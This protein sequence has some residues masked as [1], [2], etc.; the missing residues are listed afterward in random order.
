MKKR[1]EP[2]MYDEFKQKLES[3]Q[4][5]KKIW[6]F[7]QRVIREESFVEELE[8]L[9]AEWNI[10]AKGFVNRDELDKWSLETK[11]TSD[12]AFICSE[13]SL[14]DLFESHNLNIRHWSMWSFFFYNE[15][16]QTVLPIEPDGLC[17]VEDLDEEGV[18]RIPSE[19][20]ENLK[21]YPISIR[22]SPYASQR[23]IVEYVKKMYSILILDVQM[24]YRKDELSLGSGRERNPEYLEVVDFIWEHRSMKHKKLA[25]FVR[26][27]FTDRKFSFEW[28]PDYGTI[29]KIISEEKKR[30]KYE[31]K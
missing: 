9:R 12:L 2:V 16:N 29:G 28:P 31:D 3:S 13:G 5:H 25:T 24:K 30:R 6:N 23:D 14:R 17:F 20:A 4:S 21:Q 26:E 7:A 22:V 27:H 11:H 10:P 8:K 15:L 1:Q 19:E 18:T